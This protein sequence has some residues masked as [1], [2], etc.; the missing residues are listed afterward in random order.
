MSSAPIDMVLHCP[1]C[2]MQHIDVPDAHD[3]LQRPLVALDRWTNPPH[4]SH[5]CLFCGF[6]WRPADVETNGVLAI[7]TVGKHDTQRLQE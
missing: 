3:L 5:L 1:K 6:I 4:R 2:H 7:K